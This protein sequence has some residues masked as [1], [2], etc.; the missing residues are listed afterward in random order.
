[1][2]RRVTGT[3]DGFVNITGMPFEV[4]GGVAERARIGVIVLA[5]DNTVEHE[6]RRVI[7]LPG[8]AFFEARIM[9]RPADHARDAE[10][11][12]RPHRRDRHA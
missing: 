9:Q 4:D 10:A 7:D 12:G 2:N 8:V 1:M 3:E 5:T 6:F 11:H